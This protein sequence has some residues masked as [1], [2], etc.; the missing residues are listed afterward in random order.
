MKRLPMDR[1]PE[2]VNSFLE[3]VMKYSCGSLNARVNLTIS[4]GIDNT[5]V[6]RG[7]LVEDL[8]V[9]KAL[10]EI[11]RELF[12]Q[13]GSRRF[14][15]L[16]P[17]VRL[18]FAR[19]VGNILAIPVQVSTSRTCVSFVHYNTLDFRPTATTRTSVTTSSR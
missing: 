4:F 2:H 17:E 10:D 19:C 6:V 5:E 16:E 13:S 11:L 8:R 1:L 3:D 15:K 12:T 7:V 18:G 9:V 14:T